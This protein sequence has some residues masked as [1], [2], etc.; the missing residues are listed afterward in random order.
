LGV[1]RDSDDEQS[2]FEID[3]LDAQPARFPDA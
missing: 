1:D 2:P 3:V